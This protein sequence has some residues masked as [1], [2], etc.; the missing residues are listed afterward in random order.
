MGFQFEKDDIFLDLYVNDLVKGV[1]G[2][3]SLDVGFVV[4]FY[5]LFI[6]TQERHRGSNPRSSPK[7]SSH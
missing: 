5:F 7:W 1:G 6:Q 2:E 4:S 3:I